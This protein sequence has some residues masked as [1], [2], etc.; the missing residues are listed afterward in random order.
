M[1]KNTRREFL[2]ATAA[3]G[4][5]GW[6]GHRTGQA[7]SPN[8]KLNIGFIGVGGGGQNMAEMTGENVAALCDVDERH[9]ERPPK[10]FPR[11]D[12]TATSAR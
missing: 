1:T 8:D 2:I 9:L 3:V 12:S 7:R 10:N 4:V 6:L 5:L 11:R